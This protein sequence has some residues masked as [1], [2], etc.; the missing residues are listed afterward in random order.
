MLPVLEDSGGRWAKR[1][2]HRIRRGVV[3]Q[4][5]NVWPFDWTKKQ[6]RRNA[7]TERKADKRQRNR[8]SRVVLGRFLFRPRVTGGRGTWLIFFPLGQKNG[9]S[10]NEGILMQNYGDYG[11]AIGKECDITTEEDDLFTLPRGGG[12]F[13]GGNG[14]K[15]RMIL[16]GLLRPILWERRE[17][18]ENWASHGLNSNE[19]G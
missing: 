6:G 1:R 7:S 3:D 5:C 17:S 13:G 12:T 11:P 18:G 2:A 9:R 8:S 14:D 16:S 4:A 15:A 19:W 10:E